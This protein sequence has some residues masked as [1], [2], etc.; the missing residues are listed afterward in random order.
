MR[1]R[2]TNLRNKKNERTTLIIKKLKSRQISIIFFD[3]VLNH[4]PKLT[5]E[6]IKLRN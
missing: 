4:E 3:H 2:K 1:K 6:I 5:D